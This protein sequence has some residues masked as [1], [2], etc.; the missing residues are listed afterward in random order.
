MAMSDEQKQDSGVCDRCGEQPATV[1]VRR[2]SGATQE[3]LHV[4]LSCSKE[5]GAAPPA[6]G[7]MLSDPLTVLF[8]SMEETQESG[9][10]CPG[11]GLGY[12]RFKETGR[13][14]CARCYETF[15]SELRLLLRRIHGAVQHTGKAPRREGREYEEA[16]VI[17]RINEELERA[18]VSEDYERAAELRDR[19]R[20][21]NPA[22][23][24]EK[25]P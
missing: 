8:Q 22:A 25:T 18:V 2:V 1:R 3:D 7:G 15:S 21:L 11:C 10:K 24:N 19:L 14:G 4:C 5:I 6:P 20:N 16:A 12:D 9:A 23:Q 13:L 17:R